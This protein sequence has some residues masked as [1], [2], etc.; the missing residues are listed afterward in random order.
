M[1]LLVCTTTE[2]RDEARAVAEACVTAHLAACAHIDEIES[3]YLWQGALEKGSEFRLTLKISDEAYDEVEAAI[4]KLH[5]YDEPA[6][7][8]VPVTRGSASY[9]KWVAENSKPGSK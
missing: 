8:A 7:Y 3:L 6:I 9:L 4:R 5:S 2:T 1:A